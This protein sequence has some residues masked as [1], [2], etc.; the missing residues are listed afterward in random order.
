VRFAKAYDNTDWP[1]LFEQLSDQIAQIDTKEPP[2]LLLE[3]RW[4]SVAR[5]VTG[6]MHAKFGGKN[7][8][9]IISKRTRRLGLYSW[10]S[11]ARPSLKEHLSLVS[12]PPPLIPMPTASNGTAPDRVGL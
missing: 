12:T 9:T 1:A 4:A 3:G 10:A 11:R 8:G 2:L 6:L 5:Q 7:V